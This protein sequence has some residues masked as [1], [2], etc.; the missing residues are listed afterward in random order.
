M[1]AP[2]YIFI[3]ALALINGAAAMYVAVKNFGLFLS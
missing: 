3:L 2:G 1:S